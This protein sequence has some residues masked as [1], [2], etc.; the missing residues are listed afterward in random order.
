MWSVASCGA[1]VHEACCRFVELWF[2]KHVADLLSCGPCGLLQVAELWSMWS[3]AD[4]GDM[5]LVVCCMLRSCSPCGLLNVAEL[6]SVWSAA[7]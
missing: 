4:C 1:M 5:V 2:M 3:V 7:S 6:W